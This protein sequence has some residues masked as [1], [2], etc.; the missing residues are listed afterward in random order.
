MLY[1][2]KYGGLGRKKA[3]REELEKVKK[4]FRHFQTG[5]FNFRNP[6]IFHVH[7]FKLQLLTFSLK[8]QRPVQA[9]RANSV[10]H[11]KKPKLFRYE[12]TLFC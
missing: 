8:T 10:L 12:L 1:A 7:S 6:Y 4:L 5:M 11:C 3:N 9:E 2:R